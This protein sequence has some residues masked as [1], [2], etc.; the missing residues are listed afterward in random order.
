MVDLDCLSGLSEF[1][2][3]EARVN[4]DIAPERLSVYKGEVTPSLSGHI[5]PMKTPLHQ[6]PA[7]VTPRSW[8]S[9]TLGTTRLVKA[10]PSIE[11]QR[12]ELSQT[13]RMH[14]SSSSSSPKR[15]A[16]T[17]HIAPT[18]ASTTQPAKSRTRALGASCLASGV[19]AADAV[20]PRGRYVDPDSN[21]TEGIARLGERRGQQLAR[22]DSS[23]E[24]EGA[25]PGGCPGW[26]SRPIA[27]ACCGGGVS[28]LRS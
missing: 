20:T 14:P 8:S 9:S 16:S 24:G 22:V 19:A 28:G 3:G 27:C 6:H 26:P 25:S 15:S 1:Y 5:D 2:G 17:T 13:A 21:Q 12:D 18:V 10:A 7:C 4:G 23:A 11:M